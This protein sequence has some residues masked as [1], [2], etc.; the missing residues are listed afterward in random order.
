VQ[1]SSNQ[2]QSDEARPLVRRKR[3]VVPE[4]VTPPP[5]SVMRA[6]VDDGPEHSSAKRSARVIRGFIRFFVM[7]LLEEAVLRA[8]LVR[9]LWGKR[10]KKKN[11]DRLRQFALDMGGAFIK[12]GQFFSMRSDIL[13]PA[14]C[15]ALR[16]LY[17][18][19]P[20]FPTTEARRIIERELQAP[21]DELFAHF[22]DDPV[23]AASFGQAHLVVLK[24]GVSAGKSAVIKVSRPG[25]EKQ[26][27]TDTRLLMVLGY[28]VDA[29]SLL[30]QIKLAPI[31]RDFARW[32]KREVAYM[33]EAKNADHLHEVTAWNVRQRVPFIHWDY[34]TNRVLTMEYLDGIPISEVIAR[35]EAGDETLDEELAAMDCDRQVVARNLYQSFMLQAFVGHVFHADPHPGN[36]IVM[37]EN[38][39][40]FVDFGLLGR[41]NEEGRRE[42]LLV[43]D[44]VVQENIETMFVCALDVMDAPRGLAVTEVYDD[45]AEVADEWLD[46]CDNPGALMTEKTIARFVDSIMAIARQVGLVL[47]MQTMLYYKAFLTIDGVVLRVHPDFDYKSESRRAVRLIRMRELDKMLGP[48]AIIDRAL[49]VQL[50]ANSLPDF[51]IQRLQDFEQGKKTIYRKLNLLPV[52]IAHVLRFFALAVAGGGLGLLALRLGWLKNAPVVGNPLVVRIVEYLS[53][54]LYSTPVVLIVLL[55]LAK[56]SEAK[57]FKKVQKDD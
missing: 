36:L 35:F 37:P 12:F 38:T 1:E 16:S 26:I 25:S 32:I 21:I 50:L 28:L 41:L 17:D 9:R 40:G 19:V 49:S 7:F 31:F 42:Q 47:P 54:L 11:P 43:M 22:D 39:I 23:G 46:A 10:W 3:V 33:Q 53:P 5:V 52:I 24:R 2:P 20:P 51:L 15:Y 45:F 48:G 29:T 4:R 56:Y 34:T 6:P 13:P 44:A 8:P 57:S 18:E 30:G 27:A 14:Y 55:W